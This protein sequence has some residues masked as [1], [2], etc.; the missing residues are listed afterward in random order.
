MFP[1][2]RLTPDAAVSLTAGK[3][4]SYIEKQ[5]FASHVEKPG[6][7]KAT[8][9]YKPQRGEH[10][11]APARLN[12]AWTDLTANPIGS[13]TFSF[14]PVQSVRYDWVLTSPD[15]HLVVGLEKPWERPEAFGF[16]S[17]DRVWKKIASEMQSAGRT[18]HPTL[19]CNFAA[20][21]PSHPERAGVI[22]STG[23]GLIGG[24]LVYQNSGTWLINNNSGRFGVVR[25]LDASAKRA[26]LGQIE[27]RTQQRYV[28]T[29]QSDEGTAMFHALTEVA[30]RFGQNSVTAT[31]ESYDQHVQRINALLSFVGTKFH[32]EAGLRVITQRMSTH[33]G[34]WGDFK[35]F[36][37]GK[38]AQMGTVSNG[39]SWWTGR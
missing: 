10:A 18:G 37:Q 6:L 26:L 33:T 27:N 32:H 12:P 25:K 35:R 20:V 17:G 13:R 24:E 31:D 14:A 2:L 36:V 23:L 39:S 16:H 5:E 19:V 29:F 28:D 4:P 21:D 8:D 15:L 38:A 11:I 22:E 1:F 7:T 3:A 34:K 9:R 30:M